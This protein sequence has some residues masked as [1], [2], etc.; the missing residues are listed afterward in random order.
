[1]LLHYMNNILGF[2]RLL[3]TQIHFCAVTAHTRPTPPSIPIPSHHRNKS[4]KPIR[5]LMPPPPPPPPNPP[6]PPTKLHEQ[7]SQGSNALST[8]SGTQNWANGMKMSETTMPSNAEDELLEA[9]LEVTNQQN[10]D[11]TV[12]LSPVVTK[13][14]TVHIAKTSFG[15]SQRGSEDRGP[16]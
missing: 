1:M 15:D 6:D 9:W 12:S 4:S 7:T 5:I 13:L 11:G 16:R 14:P 2:Y 8:R 3:T 10:A